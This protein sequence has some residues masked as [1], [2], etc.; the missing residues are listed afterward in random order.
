VVLVPTFDDPNDG[1]AL[2]ILGELFP[3]RRIVP[4]R[5]VD[6]VLGLG[7][8]HCSTHEEPAA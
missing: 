2:G 6:L 8:I 1:R 7:T 5:A 4:I 3:G